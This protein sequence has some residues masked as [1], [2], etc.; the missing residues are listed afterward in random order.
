MPAFQ[1]FRN[2][3]GN[4]N[5]IPLISFQAASQALTVILAGNVL[6]EI[7]IK[8]RLSIIGFSAPERM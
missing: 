5:F 8:N 2:Y 1:Y 4:S 3:S 7:V 6:L